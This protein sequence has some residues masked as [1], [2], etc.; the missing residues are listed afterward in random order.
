MLGTQEKFS[1]ADFIGFQ[2]DKKSAFLLLWRDDL[3]N[4]LRTAGHE[5]LASQVAEWDGDMGVESREAALIEIWLFKMKQHIFADEL[6]GVMKDINR[7]ELFRDRVLYNTF[8][9]P[10]PIWFDNINTDDVF[11]TREQ[12]AQRALEEALDET[13]GEEW[14]TFQRLT[15][16]HPF[17][18]VPL[19][20]N[21]LDLER[22][23]FPRGGSSGTLNATLSV[24]DDD[25][26]FK[27]LGGPSWRF[28]IDF[29]NV[30]AVSM[31]IP[32]GQSGHPLDDHFFDFYGLWEKGSMWN[33]PFSREKVFARSYSILNLLPSELD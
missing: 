7:R 24:P 11:E 33:V 28:V 32:A 10:Y 9:E 4:A 5:D 15:M 20:G 1:I 23:P 18:V 3:V 8:H 12:I 26:Q 29:H 14:G 21:L 22:G 6:P 13:D 31:V 25:G 30:D 16:A 2:L 17:A 19:I 27:T